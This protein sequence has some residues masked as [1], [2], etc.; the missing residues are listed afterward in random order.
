M[1]FNTKGNIGLCYIYLTLK[2]WSFASLK[3]AHT[4][5]IQTAQ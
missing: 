3:K 5:S 4:A 2:D 1:L